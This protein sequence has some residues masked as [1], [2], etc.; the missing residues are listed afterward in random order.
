VIGR[1]R[2]FRFHLLGQH[3]IYLIGADPRN[4]SVDVR[5][6]MGAALAEREVGA[7]A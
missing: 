3:P 4:V 5:I 1:L 2:D 7:P 6:L